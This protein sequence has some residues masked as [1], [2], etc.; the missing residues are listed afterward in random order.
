MLALSSALLGT[1]AAVTVASVHSS[2]EGPAFICPLDL[3]CE[4]PGDTASSPSSPLL[5]EPQPEIC[6]QTAI[7]MI[8]GLFPN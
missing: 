8:P 5:P 7:R 4:L 6:V 2:R 1:V 3:C